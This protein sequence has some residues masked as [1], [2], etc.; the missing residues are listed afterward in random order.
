ML[1]ASYVSVPVSVSGSLCLLLVGLW[2]CLLVIGLLVLL[3]LYSILYLCCRDVMHYWQCG[4]PTSVGSLTAQLDL[5]VYLLSWICYLS[6]SVSVPVSISAHPTVTCYGHSCYQQCS[7]ALLCLQGYYILHALY[8]ITGNTATGV[9]CV[10]SWQS[11]SC[12]SCLVIL[13]LLGLLVISCQSSYWC[14]STASTH[15]MVSVLLV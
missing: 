7:T 1:L 6:V 14:Y 15:C 13:G 4:Y 5:L 11:C 2:I 8:Y 12:S 9:I 3:V 10:S